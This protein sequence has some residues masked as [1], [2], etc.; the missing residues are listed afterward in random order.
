MV[1]GAKVRLYFSI[2]SYIE[3]TLVCMWLA[4]CMK[5]G[6]I[7]RTLWP[8]A[9]SS[10]KLPHQLHLRI[11]PVWQSSFSSSLGFAQAALEASL[12]RVRGCDCLCHC[13]S[14]AGTLTTPKSSWR[15]AELEEPDSTESHHFDFIPSASFEIERRP[16]GGF[17]R[18]RQDGRQTK[19]RSG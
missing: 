12:M 16:L 11:V 9:A 18:G 14:L 2:T 7:C 1:S 5:R 6:K 8:S 19:E 15:W 10:S 3:G 13:L 4:S 17:L